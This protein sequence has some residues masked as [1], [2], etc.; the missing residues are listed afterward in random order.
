LRH[1]LIGFREVS[2]QMATDRSEAAVAAHFQIECLPAKGAPLQMLLQFSQFPGWQPIL[3]QQAEHLRVTGV[4]LGLHD[5][6]RQ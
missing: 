5:R 4:F 6:P 1:V 3:G 2:A